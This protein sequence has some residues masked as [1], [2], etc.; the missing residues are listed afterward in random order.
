MHNNTSCIFYFKCTCV[1]IIFLQYLCKVADL[2]SSLLEVMTKTKRQLCLLRA[3]FCKLW[4]SESVYIEACETVL[5]FVPAAWPVS[6]IGGLSWHVVFV[7]GSW[8][9]H[10]SH[11]GN[12]LWPLA[13]TQEIHTGNHVSTLCAQLTQSFILH[14]STPD[15]WG[16]LAAKALLQ[17]QL[18]ACL[19]SFLSAVCTVSWFPSYPLT[20]HPSRQILFSKNSS[21]F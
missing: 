18:T 1:V 14:S 10:S 4:S 20:P 11:T 19:I 9:W 12:R 3:T 16:E 15:P 13:D 7:S 21:V 6:K 8:A 17:T 5:M 2:V